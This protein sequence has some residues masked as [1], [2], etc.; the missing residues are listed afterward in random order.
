MWRLIE[1]AGVHADTGAGAA[2]D[3]DGDRDTERE[4][5]LLDGFC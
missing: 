3:R 2:V 4:C 5:L 1:I